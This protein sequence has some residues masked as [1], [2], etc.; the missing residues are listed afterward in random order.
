MS[1]RCWEQL[2]RYYGPSGRI[3]NKEIGMAK[4]DPEA[5]LKKVGKKL[6]NEQKKSNEK[7][8]RDLEKGETREK[9][10]GKSNRNS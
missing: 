5:E 9:S 6:R 10:K 4:F 3:N 1:Q 8:I 2:V 7:F